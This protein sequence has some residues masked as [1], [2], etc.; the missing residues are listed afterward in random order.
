M[1]VVRMSRCV[2][3]SLF[4]VCVAAQ[5]G[6][7]QESAP[8]FHAGVELGQVVRAEQGRV[9]ASGIMSLPLA[10]EFGWRRLRLSAGLS[11]PIPA[12]VAGAGLH[13]PVLVRVYPTS[14]GLF[15]LG[16]VRGM[17]TVADAD[18]NSGESSSTGESQKRNRMFTYGVGAQLGLGWR[19]EILSELREGVGIDFFAAYTASYLKGT[20]DR[21]PTPHSGVYQGASLSCSLVLPF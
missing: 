13:V 6:L 18:I 17:A 12:P 8:S 21:A 1:S 3:M 15:I 16:G 10:V 7:A 9:D 4:F 2:A 5:V 20:S 19:W 11:L 14:S